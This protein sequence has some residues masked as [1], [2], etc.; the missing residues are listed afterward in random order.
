V[1]TSPANLHADQ[2]AQ[3]LAFYPKEL[4]IPGLAYMIPANAPKALGPT[5]AMKKAI[6][7]LFDA[8]KMANA[9]PAPGAVSDVWDP[10]NMVVNGLRKFGPGVTAL[11]LRDYLLSIRGNYSGINGD[12]DFSSGDQHG[13]SDQAVVLTEWDP[14]SGKFY[15]VSGMRGIPL[16]N[17]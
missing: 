1:E 6:A 16:P 4:L 10:V 12:Y 14:K 13:L 3:Y 17:H 5:P 8:Y 9:E 11:Q 15:G 7:E 2:L